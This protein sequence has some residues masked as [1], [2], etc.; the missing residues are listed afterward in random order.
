[1]YRLIISLILGF[2]YTV[3][4]NLCVSFFNTDYRYWIDIVLK[5]MV[6]SCMAP[7]CHS[8]QS[9]SYNQVHFHHLPLR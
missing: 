7:A 4:I 3:Q 8:K 1:M 5:I 2:N 6:K 9:N